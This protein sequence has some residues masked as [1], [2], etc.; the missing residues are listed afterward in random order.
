MFT[1]FNFYHPSLNI[2][3]LPD[4]LGYLLTLLG[5]WKLSHL[6]KYTEYTIA[7][8]LCIAFIL[9]EATKYYTYPF[10]YRSLY[11]SLFVSVAIMVGQLVLYRCIIHGSY[12]ATNDAS[13]LHYESRYTVIALLSI[14]TY[15]FLCFFGG[16]IFVLNALALIETGYLIYI[17][18]RLYQKRA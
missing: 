6:R 9:Q 11:L 5:L 17:I 14:F 2:D 1:R 16:Y 13:I 18:V 3:L 12:K 10:L 7:K 4:I 8:L 15:L